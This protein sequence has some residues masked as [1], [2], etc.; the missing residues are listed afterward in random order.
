M[1]NRLVC[2]FPSES[3]SLSSNAIF[4]PIVWLLSV[5]FASGL[6]MAGIRFASD[7]PSPPWLAKLH[8]YAAVGA[9]SLLGFAWTQ[10]ALPAAGQYGLIALLVAAAGG[11][12]LN[13]GYHWRGRPLPEGLVFAHMSV[14]F[15]GVLIVGV[16]T[17]SLAA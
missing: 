6:A 5:A 14:A 16:V 11:L 2:S 1:R 12:L 10:A 9:I 15:I 4:G 17:L 13:L 3:D 7:R 8:G